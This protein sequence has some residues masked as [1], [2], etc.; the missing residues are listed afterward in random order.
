MDIQPI[1][2][3]IAKL[4]FFVSLVIEQEP[5]PHAL[6]LGIK[7]LPNLETRFVAADTL[8]GL[9]A[10]TASLLLHDAVASKREEV[11]AVRE[12]Y[13][14]ADSRPAKLACIAA[15]HGL[16]GELQDMLENERRT[17][18]AARKRDIES[19]A[20]ALPNPATRKAYREGELRKLAQQQRAYDA[21][22][23]DA[24]K[25]A[26]WDPYDQNARA[27][28]FNPEWMFGVADGFDLVIGNPPYV[29][30]DFRDERHKVTRAA[31]MASGGYETLWEKWDL[32]VPFMERGFKLLREGGVS[33]LIV[34]D[35][36]CHAKYA[37]KAR[38][39][40]LHNTLIERIDFYSRIKIFD[41][42]VHNLSYLVRKAGG[43]ENVP[44]RRLHA[45]AFGEV[46]ELS[47]GRQKA[48]S[49]RIFFPEEGHSPPSTRCIPL[50]GICYI[51]I[52]MVVHAH[53]SKA[54][55]AFAL[56]DIVSDME[57][58]TYSK[59]FVEGKHLDFW[60]IPSNRWLEWGTDRAPVLF[61]RKAFPEL[62]TTNEKILVQRSPGPDPKACYD[63]RHTYFDASSVGFVIWNDLKNVRNRSIQKQARYLGEKRRSDFPKREEL[64]RDSDQFSIKYLLG[65]MN[66]AAARDFLRAHRR[67]NIHLYPDDWKKLP[68]PD[69]TPEFQKPIIDLVNTI[70]AT[71]RA[72]A[73]ADV[74]DLERQIDDAVYKLYGFDDREIA[75]VEKGAPS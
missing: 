23:A 36:F 66:S 42:A 22:L 53:E 75:P 68:I 12:R 11:A 56:E 61:R 2:C 59:R 14:L 15:E 6:N 8:I 62:F 38:E 40:F 1:A 28:W 41:A 4:R 3:Q 33:S 37:L 63:D 57:D 26:A 9:Q 7:P 69:I 73:N 45:P 31:I 44:L 55:G 58:E 64:E 10:E 71:K 50:N 25:V 39:W 13:F 24:R 65:I 49:E 32:F 74:A 21:A 67:S 35:A 47:T 16:R 20:K 17:W 27:G 46:Q 54:P 51:S 5:D 60:I 29:R 34:S 70:L 30:A 18:L 72:D 52:G 48:L 43:A 19:T